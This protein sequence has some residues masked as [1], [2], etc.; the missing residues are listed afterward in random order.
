MVANV[1][2]RDGTSLEKL[3]FAQHAELEIRGGVGLIQS[4]TAFNGNARL[5]NELRGR[6]YYR[7][8]ETAVFPGEA[9]QNEP[10]CQDLMCKYSSPF[11]LPQ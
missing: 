8:N 5:S 7:S 11:R 6:A 2:R 3:A 9:V 1:F 10:H 4:R